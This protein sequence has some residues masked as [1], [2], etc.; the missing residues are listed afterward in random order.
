VT[1]REAAA[2][3]GGFPQK[4][5]TGGNVPNLS[6]VGIQQRRDVV[7]DYTWPPIVWL[8]REINAP[9]KYPDPICQLDPVQLDNAIDSS[10]YDIE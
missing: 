4:E 5:E 10:V 9:A 1:L 6:K 3:L 2:E 8:Q 7:S